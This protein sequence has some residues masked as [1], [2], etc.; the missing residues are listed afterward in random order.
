MRRRGPH[1][2]FIFPY[3]HPF[4]FNSP[5]KVQRELNAHTGYLSCCRFVSD[6][7]IIT[8]SGDMTC[9]LWDIES[10]AKMQEFTDHNGDVMSISLSPTDRYR[11]TYS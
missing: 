11:N 7:E 10:N 3:F 4:P 8:S 2:S 6:S 5:I 1:Q 9:I